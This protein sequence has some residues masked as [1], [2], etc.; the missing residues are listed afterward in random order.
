MASGAYALAAVGSTRFVGIGTFA[1]CYRCAVL[2]TTN[3]L[4]GPDTLFA[5]CEALGFQVLCCFVGAEE[6]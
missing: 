3:T 1:E 4:L 6:V 5:A 2:M